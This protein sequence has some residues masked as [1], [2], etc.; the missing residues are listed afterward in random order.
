MKLVLI[1]IVALLFNFFNSDLTFAQVNV[2]GSDDS[3][4]QN[5]GISI[6]DT[7]VNQ[8]SDSISNNSRRILKDNIGP[9]PLSEIFSISKII[10][11]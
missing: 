1:I 4:K 7:L 3:L 5:T 6:I 9:P 8:K 2:N 11:Y 10:N